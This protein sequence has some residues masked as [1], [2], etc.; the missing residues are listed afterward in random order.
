MIG[1]TRPMADR[2]GRTGDD[3][4]SDVAPLAGT[5]PERGQS[6]VEFAIALPI[7][8]ILLLGMLDFG[9]AFNHHLSLE[10]ATREGARMGA[11]VGPGT[12]AVPC[13]QVDAYVIAAVQRVITS[14]GSQVDVSRVSEIRIYRANAA[15]DQIGGQ[16]NVWTPGTGPVVDGAALL[17]GVSSTGWDACSVP[18]DNDSTPDSIGV[19]IH[20]S[21]Q[22]VTGLGA[23]LGAV[24]F[25]QLAMSDRTIMALN[26]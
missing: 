23:I 24:G 2:V 15:G 1:P 13:G 18:R 22:M 3:A 25:N 16:V 8:A 10:Y 12:A 11:A 19:G 14:P 7:L 26:P 6:L 4:S 21:Y 5:P 17:F 9:F 20:Y